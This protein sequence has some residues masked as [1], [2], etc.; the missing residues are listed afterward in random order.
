MHRTVR[1]KWLRFSRDLKLIYITVSMRRVQ[2]KLCRRI[3]IRVRRLHGMS[4]SHQGMSILPSPPTAPHLTE[5]SCRRKSGAQANHLSNN[6]R[7]MQIS[8]MLS[9]YE[10]SRVTRNVSICLRHTLGALQTQIAPSM[11]IYVVCHRFLSCAHLPA[12]P[13]PAAHNESGQCSHFG[14]IFVLG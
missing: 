3:P 9:P 1:R 13:P 2:E 7:F 6:G 10:S 12:T 5:R 14:L 8:L 11:P 4:M